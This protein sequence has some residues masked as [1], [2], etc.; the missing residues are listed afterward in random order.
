MSSCWI[1]Y[2]HLQQKG[3]QENKLG[4]VFLLYKTFLSKVRECDGEYGRAVD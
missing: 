4:M 3:N 1:S 2:E